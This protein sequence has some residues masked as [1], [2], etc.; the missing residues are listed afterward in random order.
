MLGSGQASADETRA[1]S[2]IDDYALAM[3]AQFAYAGNTYGLTG[4][5]TTWDTG[6][7][8]P[9]EEAMNSLEA[10][11]QSLYAS[12]GVIF[13]CMAVRQLVFSAVRFRY[14]RLRN[15]RP[16]ELFGSDV[17][18]VLE[19]PWPGGTTQDMLS[20]MIQDVD[21][22]GNS[23]WVTFEDELIRLRPDWCDIILE[24]RMIRGAQ[25]GWRKLAL[26][27]YEGGKERNRDNPALFLPGEVSHFAPYPDPLATYR[28]M[29]PLTP[30]LREVRADKL[31]T[32]HREKFFENAATPNLAV[33]MDPAVSYE[34]F[35]KFKEQMNATHS[36]VENAYRTLYFGAAA[37]VSVVGQNFEQMSFKTVQGA[38]ETRIAA[39]FGV[40]PIIVGLSEGLESATYSNYAQARRRLSDGTMHPLWQNVAGSLSAVMPDQGRGTRLWYDARDV[41]FL[42]EDE[43]DAA[44]IA[45]I[46]ASTIETYVRAGFTPESSV[47]A[48]ESGDR[49]LLVHSGLF[50]VQ[51][52]ALPDPSGSTG[53]VT[54]EPAEDP[55]LVQARA[56]AEMAQKLYLADGVILTADEIRA[57]LRQAG[58]DLPD[59]LPAELAATPDEPI[60]VDALA[61]VAGAI[62]AARTATGEPVMSVPEVRELLLR[63]AGLPVTAELPAEMQPVED[64]EPMPMVDPTA[65]TADEARTQR[66]ATLLAQLTTPTD[67]VITPDEAR[68]IA[69][70]MGAGLEVPAPDDLK[71]AVPAVPSAAPAADGA[72]PADDGD[73]EPETPEPDDSGEGGTDA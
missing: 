64:A 15:G 4:V 73:Q 60:Q 19:E 48:Y 22:C 29:T 11:A 31:M 50:S 61:Q 40:P 66:V 68:Q 13:A 43:K 54:T 47:A 58:A 56:I 12:N 34:M 38:G 65:P 6:S 21:L 53:D 20:R 5:H 18:A 8:E 26:A 52:Q 41:P 72:P 62:S 7:G 69:N 16:S 30:V 9:R 17:L 2:T 44:A 42:R 24:P 35:L 1:I 25:V 27:Y 57:L 14:Q 71:P 46:A 51:L 45:Q 28:G 49:G 67:K 39:A 55:L 59:E 32:T 70:Q 36:G 3:A 37:D 10:Y 23:Y 63:A 33:R